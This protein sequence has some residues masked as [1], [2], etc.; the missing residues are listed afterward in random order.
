MIFLDRVL[1]SNGEPRDIRIEEALEGRPSIIGKIRNYRHEITT[2]WDVLYYG[3]SVF[4]N[5]L[6]DGEFVLL[7]SRLNSYGLKFGDP[8]IANREF[9]EYA[10]QQ[11]LFECG[12]EG[13]D[14]CS[15]IDFLEGCPAMEFIN[16]TVMKYIESNVIYPCNNLKKKA[17]ISL[18]E[19]SVDTW[20]NKY[21]EIVN[22]KRLKINEFATDSGSLELEKKRAGDRMRKR[23]EEI[24]HF[25]H[26][27]KINGERVH[28]YNTYSVEDTLL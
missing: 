18:I 24:K 9:N 23:L 19:R 4:K 26:E 2:L 3:E 28:E 22:S 15:I 12:L 14:K 20:I 1:E 21:K 7:N 17:D 11:C 25:H 8:I 16:E 10:L 27:P 13:L 6:S 5:L